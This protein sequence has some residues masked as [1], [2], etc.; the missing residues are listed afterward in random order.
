MNKFKIAISITILVYS[1]DSCFSA[2]NLAIKYLNVYEDTIKYVS[3][4]TSIFTV[5]NDSSV[6][7]PFVNKYIKIEDLNLICNAIKKFDSI[8][9]IKYNLL[10]ED[11]IQLN[12]F[13]YFR[14]FGCIDTVSDDLYLRYYSYDTLIYE[15]AIYEL[16]YFR[17][18]SENKN[19]LINDSKYNFVYAKG[20]GVILVANPN[21]WI[22]EYE[23]YEFSILKLDSHPKVTDINL[24]N[25]LLKY[26]RNMLYGSSVFNRNIIKNE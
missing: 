26:S 7:F 6:F 10:M 21:K 2:N 12:E 3:S 24:L 25:S 22:D 1:Y 9:L 4:D 16:L 17:F 5:F 11:K 20:I 23:L 8:S 15:N 19:N 18:N 14:D 13:I